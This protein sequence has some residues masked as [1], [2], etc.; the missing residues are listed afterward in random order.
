LYT[1]AIRMIRVQDDLTSGTLVD[2][3]PDCEVPDRPLYA[4]YAPGSQTLTRVQL[5]LDFVTDWF[6]RQARSEKVAP[7]RA[8]ALPAEAAGFK[9]A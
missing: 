4:L 8:N 9:S 5:F 3:L 2:V 7:V 6:R 1:T